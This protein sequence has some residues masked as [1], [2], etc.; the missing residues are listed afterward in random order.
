MLISR[1]TL[2][3]LFVALIACAANAQTDGGWK[4]ATSQPAPSAP[5]AAALPAARPASEITPVQGGL[6]PVGAGITHANVTKGSGALPQ[7][8]GQVWREYDIR[9]YT[10]R[11]T[12]TARPEQAIV[13]WIL[14]E[15]GYE[16]WHSD[17]VGLLSANR[18]TLK[19]YH[20]PEMQ[21]I[22][23]DIVDRFVSSS[24]S[25]YAFT[26]RVATVGNPNWRAK[27]LTM[28]TPIPIQS[29]GVQGWLLAKP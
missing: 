7:D 3:V 19:V 5:A 15:T 13:D 16:A 18:E 8:K 14:R 6:A 21:A 27:A 2:A 29:P 20:T 24:A 22:V 17:P 10:L 9:P 28:M 1:I 12:T 26:L 23:A 4:A 25:G 11:V